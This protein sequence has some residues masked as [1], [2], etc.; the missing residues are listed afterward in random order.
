MIAHAAVLASE[1]FGREWVRTGQLG[2]L[3]VLD[4]FPTR[5]D[6]HEVVLLIHAP[7]WLDRKSLCPIIR[8]DGPNLQVEDWG[9]QP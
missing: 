4:V 7:D 2:P 5:A 9:V 3:R 1:W 6:D 8:K